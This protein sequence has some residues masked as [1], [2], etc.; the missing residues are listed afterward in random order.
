MEDL[1]TMTK[2]KCEMHDLPHF[3]DETYCVACTA[4][5][6]QEFNGVPSGQLKALLKNRSLTNVKTETDFWDQC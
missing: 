3:A 1:L 2:S 6:I 4:L 5:Y